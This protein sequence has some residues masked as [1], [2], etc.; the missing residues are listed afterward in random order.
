MAEIYDVDEDGTVVLRLS[1]VPGAG[2]SMVA[3]RHGDALR[4]RVAA[5]PEKGRANTAVVELVAST[6]GVEPAAVTLVSGESSRSKRVRVQ[7]IEEGDLRRRLDG[8]I[9]RAGNA[10]ASDRV[11]RRRR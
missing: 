5:P 2:R 7:G 11:A 4:V 8:A 1:V 3:G 9:D 6:L 10:G